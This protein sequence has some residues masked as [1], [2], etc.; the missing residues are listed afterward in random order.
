METSSLERQLQ[1][2]Q[3]NIAFLKG[4]HMELLHGLHMEILQLQKRCTELTCELTLKS[5]KNGQSD[6]CEHQDDC[7]PLEAEIRQKELQNVALRKELRHKEALIAALE[8]SLWRRERLFLEELKRR[9]HRMTVLNVELQKQSETA[10]QLA[11]KLHSVKQKLSN[12]RQGGRLLDKPA[13][14]AIPTSPVY[15]SVSLKRHHKVHS[16]MT[17]KICTERAVGS[18]STQQR[19]RAELDELDPMPDPALFLRAR[20]H[21]GQRHNQAGCL[22]APVSQECRPESGG[23]ATMQSVKPRTVPEGNSKCS[24]FLGPPAETEIPLTDE[25]SAGEDLQKARESVRK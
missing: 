18:D 21:H 13:D 14:K 25:E 8:D 17:D 3:R 16:K 7:A 1:S 20:W 11:F 23:L 24:N 12:S 10:A 22:A 9:S 6:D 19:R 4:E 5:S 15:T 2:V